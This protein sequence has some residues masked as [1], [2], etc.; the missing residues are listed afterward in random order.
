MTLKEIINMQPNENGIV[1][2][3]INGVERRFV[4]E[5]LIDCI[6]ANRSSKLARY[7]I[8]DKPEQTD[9]RGRGRPRI[10]KPPVVKNKYGEHRYRPVIAIL[11]DGSEQKFES[12]KAAAKGLDIDHT[13][14]PKV[15]SGKYKH[16]AGIK[17]KAA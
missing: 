10:I 9:K 5:K 14:I 7:K 1:F 16:V 4:K 13:N 12:I 3:E 8:I 11:P 15:L 6:R 2:I 17:F